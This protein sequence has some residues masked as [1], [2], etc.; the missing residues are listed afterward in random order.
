MALKLHVT[1][2]AAR[3]IERI[4]E[5]SSLNRLAAPGAV[6]KDLR[7][8]LNMLR[9]QPGIGA[10]V[11]QASSPATRRFLVDRIGHWVYYR[12]RE[13]RLEVLSVWHA[14]REQP[15]SV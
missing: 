12:V 8:A 6:R 7:A 10:K 13:D 3:E 2:R 4:A 1:L 11:D 5:W 15:P 14:S 9:A